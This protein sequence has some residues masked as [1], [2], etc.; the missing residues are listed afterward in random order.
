VERDPYQALVWL[1][2]AKAGNSPLAG[3]F[4]DA[5]RSVLTQAEIADAELHALSPLSG[6]SP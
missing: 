5:A 3:R 1:L 2:R 6:S 4:L